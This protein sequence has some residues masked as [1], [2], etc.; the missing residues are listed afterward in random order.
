[1]M[2]STFCCCCGSNG[3]GGKGFSAVLTCV[4]CFVAAIV[5]ADE[6]VA[7]SNKRKV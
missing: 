5:F 7:R 1:M 6:Q 2:G 4:Y 3:L